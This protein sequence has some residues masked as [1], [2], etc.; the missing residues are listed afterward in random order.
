LIDNFVAYY[1][2]KRSH[3]GLEYKTPEQV[4]RRKDSEPI[5]SLNTRQRGIASTE[6]LLPGVAGS[7]IVRHPFVGVPG[8][9]G[10]GNLGIFVVS[11]AAHS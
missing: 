8:I 10:I 6:G 1:H 2:T 5:E 11:T 3:R 4:D 9:S 7:R